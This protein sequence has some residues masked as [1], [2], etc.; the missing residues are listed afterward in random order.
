MPNRNQNKKITL[1]TFNNNQTGKSERRY[2]HLTNSTATSETGPKAATC[3]GGG[4]IVK[5]RDRWERNAR[6]IVY[7][8][9]REEKL[10][11]DPNRTK[12][13]R[14]KRIKL[15]TSRTKGIGAKVLIETQRIQ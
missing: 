10:S 11:F 6:L 1:N 8:K 12:R 4:S 2:L 15:Y 7:N 3:T 14:S 9:W 5:K 13:G